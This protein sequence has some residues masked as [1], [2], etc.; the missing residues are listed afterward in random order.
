MA[1]LML[2]AIKSRSSWQRAWPNQA[3]ER[4]ATRCVFISEV[5]YRAKVES[6]A[7]PELV[8]QLLRETDAVAEVHNTLRKGVPV[9]LVD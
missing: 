5:R 7:S 2:C 1:A 3:L 6:T 8:A 9:Q 4:T